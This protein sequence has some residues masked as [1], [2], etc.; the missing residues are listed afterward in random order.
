MRT[1]SAADKI[2]AEH[3]AGTT[4]YANVHAPSWLPDW[5]F[6]M[7]YPHNVGHEGMQISGCTGE[8]CSVLPVSVFPTPVYE[9]VVCVMLFF[10][11]W[12]LRHRFMR[13]LQMFGTYLIM[14]GV[15]RFL[16][17][18]V[19]VNY[20]YNWGFVHPSQAEILSVVLVLIG[21]YLVLFYRDKP[22]LTPS[23]ANTGL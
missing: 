12:K 19:R 3:L 2:V 15:E 22:G 6:G 9:M 7:T 21:A 5:L 4:P 20:K 23:D 18:L 14:V 8:Y 11:L 16:V 10:V 1:S 17:E 13:P